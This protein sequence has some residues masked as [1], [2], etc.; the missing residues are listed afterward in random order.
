MLYVR[1]I[2]ID[3]PA[4][5]LLKIDTGL[6]TKDVSGSANVSE[7]VLNVTCSR[8]GVTCCDISVQK[9]SQEIQDL[10]ERDLFVASDV[11]DLP[12]SFFGFGGEYVSVYHVI[13]VGEVT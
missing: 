4:Q 9:F 1:F 2:P 6:E 13:D 5:A 7:G 11:D 10:V 12:A 3:S 8:I